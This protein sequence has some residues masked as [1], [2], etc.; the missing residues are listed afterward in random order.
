[1]ER[2][3]LTQVWKEGR[4]L[5]GWS[6]ERAF[7]GRGVAVGTPAPGESR[8]KSALGRPN[9]CV[10]SPEL[11]GW[12]ERGKKRERGPRRV[13]ER[14]GVVSTIRGWGADLVSCSPRPP[15]GP[16]HVGP[17]KQQDT[18]PPQSASQGLQSSDPTQQPG[19]L[20]QITA[21]LLVCFL[22]NGHNSSYLAGLW[23]GVDSSHG[24]WPAQCSAQSKCLV[25]SSLK[26][27]LRV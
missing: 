10:R 12:G 9:G 3:P 7:P 13:P 25:K 11:Q 20:G 14:K 26:L 4:G 2:L 5:G 8:G 18:P 22:M 24:K 1:M 17:R 19:D 15:P 6:W 27:S 23:S 21:A 16:H